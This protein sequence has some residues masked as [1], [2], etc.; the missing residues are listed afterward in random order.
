MRG[1]QQDWQVLRSTFISA[2]YEMNEHIYNFRIRNIFMVL[3]FLESTSPGQL[4]FLAN[5]SAFE[6]FIYVKTFL[7]S[8][9]L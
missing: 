3:E 6:I 4:H 5:T 7:L 8:P 2:G 9:I 1:Q